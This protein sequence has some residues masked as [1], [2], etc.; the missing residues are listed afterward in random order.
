MIEQRFVAF[1][2][3]LELIDEVSPLCRVPGVDFGEPLQQLRILAVVSHLVVVIRTS[4]GIEREGSVRQI[5]PGHVGNNTRAVGLQCER[6]DVIHQPL[7]VA[8]IEGVAAALIGIDRLRLAEVDGI[9]FRPRFGHPVEIGLH[10]LLDLA[11][12]GEVL[13][14]LLLIVLAELRIQPLGGRVDH[15]KD[16]ASAT[17]RLF[18][19]SDFLGRLGAEQTIEDDV[20]TILGR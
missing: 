10:L 17:R 11:D 16:R 2:D 18:A 14:Q 19:G 8:I 15:I 13:V 12:R 5:Q 20:R 7:I 3:A 4:Q 9:D 1:L 6:D